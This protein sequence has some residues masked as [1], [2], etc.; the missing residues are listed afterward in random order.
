MIVPQLHDY[1]THRRLT[2]LRYADGVISGAGVPL[3]VIAPALMHLDLSWFSRIYGNYDDN[4]VL[5]AFESM[6]ASTFPKVK[7]EAKTWA[8]EVYEGSFGREYQLTDATCRQLGMSFDGADYS[9]GRQSD[10][11]HEIYVHDNCFFFLRPA[12]ESILR[13]IVQNVLAQHSYYLGATIDWS[14]VLERVKRALMDR[15]SIRL[16]S[17]PRRQYIQLVSAGGDSIGFRILDGKARLDRQ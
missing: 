1:W 9:I 13:G 12:D 10:L 2:E 8:G 11:V 3:N 17:D 6:N 16:H 15:G 5:L 7:R 4:I 14:G